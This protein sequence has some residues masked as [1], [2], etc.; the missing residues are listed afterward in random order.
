MS[1]KRKTEGADVGS[2]RRRRTIITMEMKMD[3]IRRS[4]KGETSAAIGRA[5]G[6]NRSTIGTIIKD[7]ER[8]VEHVK[9]AAPVKSIIITKQSGVLSE[10]E[11]RL[12]MWIEDRNRR[13]APVSLL[14]IQKKAKSLYEHLKP[15][16]GEGEGASKSDKFVASRGWFH[17][18]KA[19]A[20][21]RHVK[22]SAASG[23]VEAAAAGTTAAAAAAAAR[24]CP[25]GWADTMSEEEGFSAQ[26]ALNVDE[27]GSFCKKTPGRTYIAKEEDDETT[28]P[29]LVA[30][31]DD[32]GAAG[33]TADTAAD[34]V[35]ELGK[36]LKPELEADDA[37][38]LLGSHSQELT[39]VNVVEL[40]AQTLA[41]EAEVA[42]VTEPKRFKTKQLAEAFGHFEVGLALLEAQDPD[43]SRFANVARVVCGGLSCYKK[44]YEEEEKKVEREPEPTTSTSSAITPEKSPEGCPA[45]SSPA[46]Q[47]LYN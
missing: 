27:T 30:A 40:E 41:G 34:E 17:R 20:N 45:S 10:M 4:E 47:S 31:A 43:A 5:L 35:A 25:E 28:A 16:V 37:Q 2:T 33:D 15:K 29:R 22:L 38:Q 32:P 3:I 9:I 26:Q 39:N 11:K 44:I 14:Q 19:R 23:R 1:G 6:L 42:D 13:C 36:Q 21:L 12:L 24:E 7:K 46:S 18:F 8:I